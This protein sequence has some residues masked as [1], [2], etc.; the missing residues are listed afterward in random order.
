MLWRRDKSFFPCP[1]SNHDCQTS[2]RSFIVSV[3]SLC[4]PPLLFKTFCKVRLIVMPL[5]VMILIANSCAELAASMWLKCARRAWE[6]QGN[7]KALFTDN[8][9]RWWM[10][11]RSQSCMQMSSNDPQLVVVAVRAVCAEVLPVFGKG[12]YVFVVC[13]RKN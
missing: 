8:N 10:N 9:S 6:I 3:T 5:L 12:C 7:I 2:S 4:Q 11:I 13:S 1:D